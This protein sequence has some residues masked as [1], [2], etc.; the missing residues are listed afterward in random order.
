MTELFQDQTEDKWTRHS[1]ILEQ[2]KKSNNNQTRGDTKKSHWVSISN[3]LSCLRGRRISFF[4]FFFF[5]LCNRRQRRLFYTFFCKSCSQHTLGHQPASAWLICI[6]L[7]LSSVATVV[8]LLGFDWL[9]EFL[10]LRLLLNGKRLE[11]QKKKLKKKKEIK[12]TAQNFLKSWKLM[13]LT[14]LS[15]PSSGCIRLKWILIIRLLGCWDS[16]SRLLGS[17]TMWRRY[18]IYGRRWRRRGVLNVEYWH[19]RNNW[20]RHFNVNGRDGR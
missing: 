3:R 5:L 6:L 14:S 18:L 2:S 9:I 1:L 13:K 19:W 12:N 17:A 4:S 15:T 10:L 11:L 8:Q 20:S 16:C 7:P